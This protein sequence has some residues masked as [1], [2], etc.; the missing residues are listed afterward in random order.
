MFSRPERRIDPPKCS[1]IITFFPQT[2]IYCHVDHIIED[3]APAQRNIN[4][5]MYPVVRWI[6]KDQR[7]FPNNRVVF[8]PD[9]GWAQN[10]T[11]RQAR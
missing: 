7:R 2:E 11:Y 1:S 4:G 8:E 9:L 6:D 10:Y 3:G 5:F